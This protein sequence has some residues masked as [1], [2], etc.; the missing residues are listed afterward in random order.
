[1]VSCLVFLTWFHSFSAIST[2]DP[3]GVEWSKMALFRYLVVGDSCQGSHAASAGKTELPLN[4]YRSI[5]G[6]KS[7]GFRAC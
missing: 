3:V 4:A 5:P 7:K 6:D 1:M 2:G